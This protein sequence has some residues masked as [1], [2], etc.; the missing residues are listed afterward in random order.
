MNKHG[1]M[2]MTNYRWTI[3]I[4]MFLSLTINYLD[5]QVLSLTWDEFIK[6]EFHWNEIHYGRITATF[7]IV[8]A[9][10]MLFAG[11]VIGNEGWFLVVDR[12]V[13]VGCLPACFLWCGNR[14]LCRT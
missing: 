5:R 14:S 7:S 13:V 2:K 9:I 10:G 8:Y 11:R 6:P 12:G 3:C 4:M 1:E